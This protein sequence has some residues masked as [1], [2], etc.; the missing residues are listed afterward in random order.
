MNNKNIR[1]LTFLLGFFL[2][3]YAGL[4]NGGLV[5]F[6]FGGNE[7]YSFRLDINDDFFFVLVYFTPYILAKL[8]QKYKAEDMPF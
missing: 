1:Y 8:W 4:H 5:F 6:Y 7:S 3:L 2:T